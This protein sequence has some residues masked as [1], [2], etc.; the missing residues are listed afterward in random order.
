MGRF[1]CWVTGKILFCS[2]NLHSNKIKFIKFYKSKRK[3]VLSRDP[4]DEPS[5][6]SFYLKFKT[7]SDRKADEKNF[8]IE[9]S[10]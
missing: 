6:I 8:G 1:T 3:K 2:R 10:H 5:L 9:N 7:F 4:T